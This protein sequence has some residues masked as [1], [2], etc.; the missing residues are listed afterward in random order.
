MRGL[1]SLYL[2]VLKFFQAMGCKMDCI[3]L[4]LSAEWYVFERF[5]LSC[6]SFIYIYIYQKEE[7]GKSWS[8][9]NSF[10]QFFDWGHIIFYTDKLPFFSW[11]KSRTI[12]FLCPL[13]Y[14]SRVFVVVYSDRLY[15]KLFLD[16]QKL[17]GSI[18]LCLVVSV[19]FQLLTRSVFCSDPGH[20]FAYTLSNHK[21]T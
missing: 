4:V 12:H 6:R 21:N 18:F 20:F 7:W 8:L 15:Q 14:S 11:G 3:M 9:R 1:V 13:C 19:Y 17:K 10:K 2:L 5:I 16:Q